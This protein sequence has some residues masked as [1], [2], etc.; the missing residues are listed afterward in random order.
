MNAMGPTS[1]LEPPALG[2][3]L[4]RAPFR[5]R[6]DEAR[7][8]RS[9]W[10]SDVHLGTRGCKAELL[11]D[12][13]AS[14]RC[15]RLYLVGDII[16]GWALRRNVYWTAAH[17][18]VVQRVFEIGRGGTDVRYVCGNHDEF[19]RSHLG[20][21][22][23]GVT[24]VDEAV[25][26][27][28][29]GRRLLVVHGDHYD[30]TIR[31]S[32]WLAHLG[33]Q[34]Y[35]FSLLLNEAV[36]WVRRRLGRPYWSLSAYLKQ[37]VKNA[38]SYIESFENAVLEDARARGFDGVV[39]GHIHHAEVREVGGMIYANDG[40]WV[41]SCTALVE[42]ESGRLEILRWTRPGEDPRRAAPRRARPAQADA[43]ARA[44]EPARV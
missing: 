30:V 13:L 10:I 43:G 36:A 27:T 29:D 3:A 37:R 26:E 21:D 20:I 8:Y 33:D 5:G 32:P 24:V 42:H 12:F 15:D 2:R 16:D 7:R 44:A 23:G 22:M 25:H 11:E 31:N 41:E 17:S 9:V 34:A 1:L 39:C 4:P 38:V 19:L 14:V 18:R 28:A 40:D 35:R 6:E